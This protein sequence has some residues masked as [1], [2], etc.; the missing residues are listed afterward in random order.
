MTDFLNLKSPTKMPSTAHNGYLEE[1][2]PIS[3]DLDQA[4]TPLTVTLVEVTMEQ[5]ILED[6]ILCE[7][8]IAIDDESLVDLCTEIILL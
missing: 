8:L 1:D 2:H 7:H 6:Q 4:K 5:A 3:L